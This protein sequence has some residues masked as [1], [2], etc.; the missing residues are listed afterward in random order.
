MKAAGQLH[1][2]FRGM[3]GLPAPAAGTVLVLQTAETHVMHG[4]RLRLQSQVMYQHQLGQRA[5]SSRR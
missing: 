5:T 4:V 3:C 1:A 2:A